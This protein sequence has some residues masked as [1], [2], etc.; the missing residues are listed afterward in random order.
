MFWEGG[1]EGGMDGWMCVNV[2]EWN[3]MEGGIS[4]VFHLQ[5]LPDTRTRI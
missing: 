4:M 5:Y 1:R 3:G 2:W